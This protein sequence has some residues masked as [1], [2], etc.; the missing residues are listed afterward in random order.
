MDNK[1]PDSSCISY[2]S[3]TIMARTPLT[4]F[5]WWCF[6][7]EQRPN[8]HGMQFSPLISISKAHQWRDV[9][10]FHLRV[11]GRQHLNAPAVLVPS[12]MSYFLSFIF[13]I[14]GPLNRASFIS[15][16]VKPLTVTFLAFEMLSIKISSLI[17]V[18]WSWR[19]GWLT[20]GMC[21]GHTFCLF[22]CLN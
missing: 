17:L 20:C 2:P 15:H 21:L 10:I 19:L 9:R 8:S 6:P 4:S 12:W 13:H 1:S 3:P 11:D 7:P 5:S 18:T 22:V 14:R 16:R